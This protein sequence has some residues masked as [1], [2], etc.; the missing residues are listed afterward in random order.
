MATSID[1]T[2]RTAVVDAIVDLLD[3]GEVEI[4]TGSAADPDSAA[5]GTI[6]ATISL[7]ATAFNAASDNGTTATATAQGTLEDT[8]A[9]NGGT[10]G[11][12]VA[13]QS[14]GN[15][16]LTGTVTGTG[17]GGDMELNTTTIEAAG[18]VTITSWTVTCG[19][20]QS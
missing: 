13:K 5:T 8:N 19:Q 15:V 17:G 10:A 18:T 1:A 20:A 16:L 9:A 4:R 2:A 14:G 11:H 3:S 12:F 6:L 7:A